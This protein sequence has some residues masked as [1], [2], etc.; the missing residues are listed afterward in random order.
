M[1]EVYLALF[2]MNWDK[3]PR[4]NG[5]TTAFW[6]SCWDVVMEDIMRMFSEFHQNGKFV[7]CLTQT[8]L[9]WSRRRRQRTSRTLDQSAL[10]ES[11]YKLL[12]KVLAN[13]L[14]RVVPS[15][16]NKSLECL[17]GGYQILDASLIENE[18]IDSML[19]KKESRI[20]CKLGIEMLMITWI[21][22]SSKDSL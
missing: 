19:K 21:G 13:R 4:L 5:F 12:G 20:L 8:S 10:S 7:S 11:L 2:E 15:P 9:S 14:K 6:Q 1:D 22:T 16:I 17:C 3:G 18:M